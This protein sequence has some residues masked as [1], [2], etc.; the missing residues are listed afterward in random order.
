MDPIL[1]HI[2]IPTLKR[3]TFQKFDI[4]LATDEMD[5]S[6]Y[7][8]QGTT[9]KKFQELSGKV[10]DLLPG[11]TSFKTIPKPPARR[12][13]G[14]GIALKLVNPGNRSATLPE[15]LSYRPDEKS[16]YTKICTT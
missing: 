14:L 6:L 8:V 1:G 16:T 3:K 10:A 13:C 5:Y 2:C 12:T 9:E 11:F 7:V 4:P 15:S